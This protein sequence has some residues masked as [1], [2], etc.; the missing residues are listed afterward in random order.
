MDLL[1]EQLW[2]EEEGHLEATRQW[3]QEGWSE[4]A[5]WKTQQDDQERQVRQQIWQISWSFHGRSP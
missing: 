1:K 3:I 2:I 5:R 4:H